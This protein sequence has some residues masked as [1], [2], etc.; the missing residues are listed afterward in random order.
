MDSLWRAVCASG[1]APP[2]VC[3]F[4]EPAALRG[5]AAVNL[6]LWQEAGKDLQVVATSTTEWNTTREILG[7]V[8][9]VVDALLEHWN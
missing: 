3:L 4:A 9:L 6:Q 5:D 7:E 8:D 2:R 1:A